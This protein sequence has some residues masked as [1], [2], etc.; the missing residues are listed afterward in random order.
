[1]FN[2]YESTLRWL[3]DDPTRVVAGTGSIA[4]TNDL[5]KS[6]AFDLARQSINEKIYLADQQTDGRGRG[7][8][9]WSNPR[10][11]DAL[12]IT[13]SWQ[14]PA[15]PQAITGPLMGLAVHRALTSTFDK[16]SFLL[17]PPNDI[18]LEGRKILG[19]LA[20][21]VQQGTQHR[22]ILGLGLNVF[23]SPPEVPI[24]GSLVDGLAPTDTSPLNLSRW[25]DFL[26]TLAHQVALAREHCVHRELIHADCHA[27][28]DALN[29][30]GTKYRE[31]RP[32]GDLV[33]SDGKT[34]SWR[35]L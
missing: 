2:V 28:L 35:D 7:A 19:L 8:N 9:T 20:E 26:K 34:T 12:L 29:A 24:A 21:A 25:R 5:A 17:K 22:L 30:S 1:M 15:A 16:T 6:E 18:Y 11:G 23:S 31:V 14:L 4:S 33:A 32:N 27:L 3:R 13:W 10:S